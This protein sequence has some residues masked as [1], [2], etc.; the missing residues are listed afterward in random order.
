M[1]V[2][3]WDKDRLEINLEGKD[4]SFGAETRFSLFGQILTTIEGYREMSSAVDFIIGPS[5]TD[6]HATAKWEGHFYKIKLSGMY[7]FIFKYPPQ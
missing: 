4:D 7:I 3:K 5:S 2:L 1:F 6:I